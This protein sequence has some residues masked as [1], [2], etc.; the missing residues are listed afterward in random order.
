M[1]FRGR[2]SGRDALFVV[3]LAG[4]L[5]R[6]PARLVPTFLLFRAPWLRSPRVRP[7]AV[8]RGVRLATFCRLG[9]RLGNAAVTAV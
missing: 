5:V 9:P 4:M 7:W 6:E 8:S 3:R 2:L 1:A